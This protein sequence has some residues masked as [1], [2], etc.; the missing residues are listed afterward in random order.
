MPKCNKSISA[1]ETAIGIR[2]RCDESSDNISDRA[3]N[4]HQECTKTL[5]QCK[6]A[7]SVPTREAAAMRDKILDATERLM[8]RL[9]YEK[10]T[11]DDIAREAAIGRRTIYLYFPSK[12]ETALGTIDRIVERVKQRLG[13]LASASLPWDERLRRMVLTRVMF[14]FDSV[15][16]YYHSIDEIFRSL[17]SSYMA[18]RAR[19]FAEEA[20]LFADVLARGRDEGAFQVDDPEAAA[21]TLL[22]ATNSLLPSSL[23]T[24]EL[25]ERAEVEAR[26]AHIIDLF[27]SGLRPR[28]P[29]RASRAAARARRD[30]GVTTR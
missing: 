8:A 19:Y 30:R 26:A 14:R 18:R 27:L 25:G 20:E 3:A 5:I 1:Q 22:L 17:R 13:E 4:D 15:R 23:S 12:E 2:Q 24:R 16:S 28:E 7:A 10:M 6:R 21:T 29:S 9:G 11:M